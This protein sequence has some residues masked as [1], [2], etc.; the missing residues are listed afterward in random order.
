MPENPAG[1]QAVSRMLQ[2]EIPVHVVLALAL[3]SVLGLVAL[4]PADVRWW[5][6]SGGALLM[7]LEP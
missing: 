1:L 4:S 6:V 2:G 5:P 3:L 7:P